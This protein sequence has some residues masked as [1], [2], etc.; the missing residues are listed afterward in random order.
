MYC[1]SE[2]SLYKLAHQ[3]LV[4]KLNWRS[5]TTYN[6]SVV[7]TAFLIL[8]NYWF[9]LPSHAFITLNELHSYIKM[10]VQQPHLD[11][12]FIYLGKNESYCICKTHC[13]ISV[14]FYT[15][16]IPFH[17]FIIFCSNNTIFI[18]HILKLKQQ[19]SHLEVHAT[20][21]YPNTFANRPPLAL[22]HNQGSSHPCTHK[23]RVR[24]TGIQIKN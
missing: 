18:N 24:M 7:I 12:N 6:S 14:L 15:K 5:D 11:I 17:Y 16:C 4:L 3:K 23:Y 10:Q 9:Y 22:Q 1:L 8:N 19:T 2:F 13:I 21:C 20:Q